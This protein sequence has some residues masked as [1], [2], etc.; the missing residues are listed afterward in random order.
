MRIRLI[1]TGILTLFIIFISVCFL[2][3]QPEEIKSIVY[4]HPAGYVDLSNV[5]PDSSKD[6]SKKTTSSL[7]INDSNIEK[8]NE[9][10]NIN[11]LYISGID[12]SKIS[13][14][15]K[16]NIY[17]LRIDNCKNF[18]L[19]SVNRNRIRSLFINNTAVDDFDIIESFLMLEELHIENSAIGDYAPITKLSKLKKISVSGININD[20][21]FFSDNT[22]LEDIKI[23]KSNISSI[24]GIENFQNLMFLHITDSK[25]NGKIDASA[26]KKLR[27]V[28]FRGNEIE[29]IILP[30]NISSLYDIDL[31]QNNIKQ[32]NIQDFEMLGKKEYAHLNLYGNFDLDCSGLKDYDFIAF[33]DKGYNYYTF[34]EYISYVA[35]IKNIA[36]ETKL[37]CKSDTEKA[38]YVFW[39]ISHLAKYDLDAFDTNLN[40]LHTGY[41]AIINKLAV[42]E[43]LT[44]AYA[45]IMDLLNVE[46]YLYYGDLYST[47]DN[48]THVWNMIK[49]DGRYYHC[50]LTRSIGYLSNMEDLT[51]D[52]YVT[53]EFGKSDSDYI[54]NK[55]FLLDIH[56]PKAPTSLDEGKMKELLKNLITIGGVQ[57]E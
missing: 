7:S 41:G 45:D 19:N 35:A 51:G 38:L 44:Y 26:S 27:T 2:M 36:K 4:H 1:L 39:Y 57:D 3:I 33:R 43:G 40:T 42:C 14:L 20:L 50:D 23:S 30:K 16:I 46:N 37:K 48:E 53:Q 25:L 24:N 9:Y 13:A 15:N 29:G 49:I 8:L 52:I 11:S 5:S 18:S 21:N 12:L 28:N 32:I 55:Y 22:L 56:A 47:K 17:S 10:Q 31:S 54:S 34:D 6:L